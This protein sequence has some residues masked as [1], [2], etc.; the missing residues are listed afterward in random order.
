MPQKSGRGD[1]LR[2]GKA[3][4]ILL[5]PDNKYGVGRD[6]TRRLCLSKKHGQQIHNL[7]P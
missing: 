5:L 1:A 4:F 3:L 7:L 2:K 6:A